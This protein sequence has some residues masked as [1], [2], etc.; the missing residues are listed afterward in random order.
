[1]VPLIQTN[2]ATLTT[3]SWSTSKESYHFIAIFITNGA[4]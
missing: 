1:M 4:L 3:I 2:L